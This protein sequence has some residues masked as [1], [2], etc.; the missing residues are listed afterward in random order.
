MKPFF[1]IVLFG[2]ILSSELCM[3]AVQIN[4]NNFNDEYVS[5]RNEIRHLENELVE[6]TEHLNKC[7]EKNKNFKIAGVATVGLAGAGIATN[8]SLYD[9]IKSQQKRNEQLVNRI[10]HA[11]TLGKDVEHL[12]HLADNV[13]MDKFEQVFSQEISSQFTES[14]LARLEELNNRYP[15]WTD[16]TIMSL[17]ASDKELVIKCLKVFYGSVKK[18][19]K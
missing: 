7:A 11:K 1:T 19:Q 5:L 10:E 3:A 15:E 18:S 9:K 13:D 14:E 6:K 8:I 12:E 4:V 16:E 2:G 17:P